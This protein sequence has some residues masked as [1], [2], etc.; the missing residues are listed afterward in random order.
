MS[1]H[2]ED[3]PQDVVPMSGAFHMAEA[4]RLIVLAGEQGTTATH[5]AVLLR[6]AE[7]H[8]VLA[9]TA[10]TLAVAFAST[11]HPEHV[12][13]YWR[14]VDLA[15]IEG[16]QDDDVRG[17]VRQG[18]GEQPQ[19]AEGGPEAAVQRGPV[20]GV[21]SPGEASGEADDARVDA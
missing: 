20:P 17:D 19:G 1:R 2:A 13:V 8:A 14:E 16:G 3:S 6:A 11:R 18:T 21:L 12:D 9:Q 7:V 5:Q 4:N 15:G 10:A